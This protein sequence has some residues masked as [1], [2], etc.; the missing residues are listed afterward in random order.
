VPHDGSLDS[1]L[2]ERK[3]MLLD[4]TFGRWVQALDG[5]KVIVILDT[6]HSGG[7]IEG[8]KAPTNTQDRLRYARGVDRI[9]KPH[10]EKWT[11]KHF[12]DTEL[13]RSKAIGQ[14][15]AAVLASATFKQLAFERREGD[16]GVMTYY[17]VEKLEQGKGTLTL[18]ELAEYARPKVKKY[19]ED[20]FIGATQDVVF[21]D[22][23]VSPPAQIRK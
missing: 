10:R 23:Q 16:L 12:L 9:K 22:Q 7:Q 21:S 2:E 20:E 17:L 4:K 18:K 11:K 13:L 1:A 8:M 3:T 15:N 14:K 5:R 6:C 19:V